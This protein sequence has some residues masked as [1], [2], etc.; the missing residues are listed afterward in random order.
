MDRVDS[1]LSELQFSFL[2]FLVGQNY[3]SFEHWKRLVNVLCGCYDAILKYP[4]LYKDL[5]TDL[6][7]QVLL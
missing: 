1:V 4:Q 3:D 2:C 5:I 6:Y 7:F